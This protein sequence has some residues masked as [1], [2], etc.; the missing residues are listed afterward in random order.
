MQQTNSLYSNMTYKLMGKIE[1]FHQEVILIWCVIWHMFEWTCLCVCVCVV[2]KQYLVCV[3]WACTLV[4]THSMR[5]NVGP[6][7]SQHCVS[8]PLK[9]KHAILPLN[10]YSAEICDGDWVCQAKL[11]HFCAMPLPLEYVMHYNKCNALGK[12]LFMHSFE[13]TVLHSAHSS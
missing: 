2:F 8:S 12:G 10:D 7:L 9:T 3:L 13:P 5:A 6:L 4:W 1:Y 11:L